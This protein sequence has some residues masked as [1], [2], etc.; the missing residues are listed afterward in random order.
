[1]DESSWDVR[2]RRIARSIRG[3]GWHVMGV[4]G[5]EHDDWSYSIGLWHSFRSPEVCLLGV[6]QAAGTRFV[7]KVGAQIRDGRPLE[8]GA[9]RDGVLSDRPV[10]FRAV[11]RSWHSSLFG[12]GLDFS[13]SPPWPVAQMFWPDEAGLFPWEGGADE[14]CRAGQPLMWLDRAEHPAEHP[15]G[16]WTGA[17]LGVW[18]FRPTMPFHDVFTSRAVLDGAPVGLVARGPDGTW[19]F[20]QADAP[21][22]GDVSVQLARVVE[23]CADLF[24][25]A[26]LAPGGWVQRRSDGSW[27]S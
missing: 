11:H 14:G 18:P 12:A 10:E 19:H 22:P 5:D 24:E 13:Q 1:M 20:V 25:V 17:E 6:P 26:G 23:R 3:F 2:D 15:A 8:F 21:G 4:F 7:N 27:P 16:P 9:L